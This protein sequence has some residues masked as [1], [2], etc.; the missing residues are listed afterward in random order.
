ML[1]QQTRLD[2]EQYFPIIGAA[3]LMLRG[4]A[5][6]TVGDERAPQYY[7]SSFH[8]LRGVPF[9]D[10]DFLLGREFFYSTVELQF[11][12]VTFSEFPL[13]DLEGVLAADFGGVG[14]GAEGV[15]EHRVFDLVF[16]FNLG[17]A[18]IVLRVHFAQPIDIGAAAAE[19][20][21]SDLQP[22]DRLALPLRGGGGGGIGQGHGHGHGHG[23]GSGVG[24][25]G[26]GGGLGVGY[27]A[28]TRARTRCSVSVTATAARCTR[29][30]LT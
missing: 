27:S 4:A 20:R 12:I 24:G 6:I 26:G 7:L 28:R 19:R 16:G 23:V 14:D 30:G 5:G 18:P 3:N 29:S 13:I 10:T 15:W 9:G 2:A 11:P 17:F 25:V 1:Y 21:R 8:T 22:V